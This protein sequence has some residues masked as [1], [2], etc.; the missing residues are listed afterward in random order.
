MRTAEE[1]SDIFNKFYQVRE[2]T[3]K[4]IEPLSVEDMIIQCGNDASPIR[5]HLAHTTW[6]FE[7]FLLKKF[8]PD[9]TVFDRS[10]DYLFNSYY[11]TVGS[12][13]PK[14]LRGTQSRPGVERIL[15]YRMRVENAIS[16]HIDVLQGEEA[17]SIM[18]LGINHE[19]QHQELMFMDIKY[20]FFNNPTFP[21]YVEAKPLPTSKPGKMNYIH[22]DA[23][24]FAVGHSDSGF[25]FDNETPVHN[26]WLNGF[27]IGDRLVTNGEYLEFIEDGGYQNPVY[28]LSDGI[29]ASRKNNWKA[30]LYWVE[31]ENGWK[32][33]TL[34]GLQD[35][36]M[37]DPVSH[38]S[39][40]EADAYARWAGKR[41]PREEEWEVA[42][43][44]TEKLYHGNF[45]DSWYLRPLPLAEKDKGSMQVLGDLWEWTQSPYVPY[46]GSSPLLG[47]VGEYNHKFMANQMVLRGGSCVTPADHIRLTYRNF[48]QPDKRWEFSGIRLAGDI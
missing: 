32:N 46:P 19:E 26:V 27:E 10:F 30:P 42:F 18:E 3:L 35:I 29:E 16:S 47:S 17:L 6:F 36:N 48:F 13:F 40:Y 39:F 31:E 43:S 28:W 1:N 25:S 38:V 14:A 44:G 8:V 4:I 21:S 20:N 45:M 9:Y 22:H 2:R 5:W 41:L 15:E 12:Y 34:S 23:G 7:K 37:D 33:F 11:E 24:L